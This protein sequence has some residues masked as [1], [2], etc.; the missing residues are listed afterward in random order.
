[1]QAAVVEVMDHFTLPHS[2]NAEILPMLLSLPSFRFGCYVI[3]WAFVCGDLEYI[4]HSA[5]TLQPLS[6]VSPLH[7]KKE[8]EVV[9]L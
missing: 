9:H 1:M 5:L 2:Y 4:C 3:D 7:P 8:V 6:F